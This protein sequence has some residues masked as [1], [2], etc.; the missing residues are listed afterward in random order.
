MLYRGLYL[1]HV[2]SIPW[3]VSVSR[4]ADHGNSPPT[5]YDL[6]ID[7]WLETTERTHVKALLMNSFPNDTADGFPCTYAVILY[8]PSSSKVA[9]HRMIVSNSVINSMIR[10]HPQEGLCQWQI[11]GP[12]LIIKLVHGV[13]HD[14]EERDLALVEMLMVWYVDS[15]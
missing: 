2:A 10:D 15:Q 8:H 3:L 1:G 14:M 11:R 12:V 13:V 5:I 4:K 7:E 6:A 9:D